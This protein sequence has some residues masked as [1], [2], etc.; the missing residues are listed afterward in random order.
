MYQNWKFFILELEKSRGYPQWNWSVAEL[1]YVLPHKT[2]ISSK[3][4]LELRALTN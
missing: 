2:Y 1:P 3:V 4:G